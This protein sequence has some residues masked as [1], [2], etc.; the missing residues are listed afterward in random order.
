MKLLSE[1]DE[2]T[3]SAGTLLT[4]FLGS[5]NEATL[6]KRWEQVDGQKLATVEHKYVGMKLLSER[7][8]NHPQIWSWKLLHRQVGMKLLSERDENSNVSLFLINTS[9]IV[10][11]KLLSERDEN[12][13]LLTVSMAK[14]WPVGMKLLSER[15]ENG[16]SLKYRTYFPY[17][18]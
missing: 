4:L 2:N 7:D 5:R 9:N 12:K 18:S 11:M 13:T 14:N 1:R 16:L 17:K 15:D 10:G 8:E 6:W 3:T